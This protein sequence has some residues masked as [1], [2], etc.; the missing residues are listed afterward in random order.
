MAISLV[1]GTSR[2]RMTS[3]TISPH[4][5]APPSNQ[6]TAPYIAL[7]GWWS[8][9]MTKN[10]SSPETPVR[11]SSLHSS[12][13][14]ASNSP[15]TWLAISM[16]DTPGNGRSPGGAWSQLTR[17]TSL[18]SARSAYASATCDPIESPSGFRCEVIRNRCRARISSRM[19]RSGS[20]S[21]LAGFGVMV[22]VGALGI[23]LVDL[24]DQ[25][26]HARL[27]LD[28]LVEEELEHRDAPQAQAL[29]DLVLEE[30]EWP[31]AAP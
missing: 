14:T 22:R 9:L 30:R 24:P 19:R 10:R 8:M 17:R 1:S 2:L 5:A 18:P 21:V 23:G 27:V 13:I 15:S 28:R 16:S 12:T 6:L 7:P 11:A 4:A 25:L 20:W 29:A 3:N 31:A 26:F